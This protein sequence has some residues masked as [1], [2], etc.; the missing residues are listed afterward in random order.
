MILP[1]EE[2]FSTWIWHPY[3]LTLFGIYVRMICVLSMLSDWHTFH[4]SPYNMAPD[5]KVTNKPTELPTPFF[6]GCATLVKIICDYATR[7]ERSWCPSRIKDASLFI[8]S[9]VF[10]LPL[11]SFYWIWVIVAM[12]KVLSNPPSAFVTWG[13]GFWGWG[14]LWLTATGVVSCKGI[15]TV[16]WISGFDAHASLD[17]AGESTEN[18]VQTI[19]AK[20]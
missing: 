11:I 17:R 10:L 2:L 7:I 4:Y 8:R 6:L 14:L 9:A 13:S 19:D 5:K 15:Y 1:L 18:S 20:S 3:L 12:Q 16:C